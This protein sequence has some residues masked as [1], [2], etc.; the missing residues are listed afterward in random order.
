MAE[1][2]ITVIA[3]TSMDVMARG[4]MPSLPEWAELSR[5]ALREVPQGTM[6]TE[7]RD[8]LTLPASMVP[9]DAQRQTITSH[10][11][12]LERSLTETPNEGE[13]WALKTA[14]LIARML[15]A[16]SG[17]KRD[18]LES[19]AKGEAYAMAL[20]DVPWW[21][22]SSA[23]RAWYRKECG[24]HNYAWPPDPATLRTISMR[25]WWRAA[26]EIADMQKLLDAKPYVD[27]AAE[28]QKYLE[29]GQK[30]FGAVMSA[31]ANNKVGELR[32]KSIDEVA[33]MFDP[34]KPTRHAFATNID[35]H[36][37]SEDR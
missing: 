30:A 1:T 14:E 17:N 28:Y 29:R 19:E 2:A 20:D 7:F 15:K 18:E 11:A 13:G 12:L 4:A 31:I 22:V 5:A 16:L 24:E 33:A 27:C 34:S 9:N 26:A 10:K 32:G 25:F 8:T 37:E 35:E 23:I 3:R 21:A 36:H 6:Q